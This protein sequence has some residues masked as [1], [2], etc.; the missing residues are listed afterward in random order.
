MI[1]IAVTSSFGIESIVS[2][3]LKNLGYQ[4]LKIDNGRV[5]FEGDYFDVCRANIHL[6]TADRVLIIIK[7]FKAT[8][9]DQLFDGV[10]EIEWQDILP[11]DANIYV[12]GRS[13]KSTLFSIRDCQA[14]TKKAIIEKLKKRYNKNWFE[15]S[16]AKYPIEIALNNDIATI[17]LD[18]S[19][20][21]LHK[22]GYRKYIGD[23]PIKETLASAMVLLSRWR[24]SSE[25]LWDPFCGSGTIAIEAALYAKNI[26]PG[27]NKNFIS[28]NWGLIDEKLWKE[29]RIKALQMV[30]PNE[31]FEI[32][33]SDIDSEV[34]KA[35]HNNAKLAGVDKDIRIF[36]ED[37]TK[38]KK[39]SEKGI[40]V[41]NPPYGERISQSDLFQLYKAFG[42]NLKEFIN[43]RFFILSAFEDFEK[44]FGRKAD[45]NRK[46]FNGNIKSY[47]YFYF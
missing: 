9:F 21:S 20:S 18:T 11:Q 36:K 40:I 30:K 14:I 41:C 22:R 3:E 4:N 24:T 15:E 23:A 2:E 46:L 42:K 29:A 38:I 1:K 12:T 8:T 28:E 37:A 6:R 43:W 47:L 35:A 34:L 26:A 13:V 17:T 25:T 31:K 44:A 45:R 5:L 33:A 16:G 27:L 32:L 10:Y 7:Q 39:S 19:G